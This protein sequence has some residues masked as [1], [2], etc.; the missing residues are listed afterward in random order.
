MAEKKKRPITADAW[1]EARELM[2][3]HRRSLSVGM[4]LMLINRISGLVLPASSKYLIDDVVGKG[5]SRLLVPLAVAVGIA[6]LIQA[7]TSFGLSQVISVAAQRAITEMR[8][9]VQ[10]QVTRLPIRFFDSTQS[11]VLVS[12]IMTD[13]EGIRNLV[14]TGIVQLVGGVVTAML[15][16]GV[17]IYLN[18][19]LTAAIIL[20]LAVF[21]GIMAFAFTRLR[22]IFRERSEINA[23]VTGRLT[24]T[25]GGIRVVKAYGT[26]KRE[27]RVF[28]QGAHRLFRNVARSITGVSAVTAFSTVVIGVVGVLMILVGGRAILDGTMTLG[29]LVMYIF[30]TGLLAAPVVQMASIG[31]QISEAFAGLD[32]IRELR[33]MVTEQDE[34]KDREPLESV[35]GDIT[36]QDVVFEYNAGVPVLKHVSFVAPAGT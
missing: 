36:F 18:W 7:V 29:D 31:T 20:L 24:E 21:G 15:A 12:R 35:H 32:R 14:G 2:W 3:S 10:A 25:L 23:A 33:S 8:R 5:Q 19:Q 28:T 6:T 22:P 27:Q 17:L 9:R 30:F 26:E 11:G 13:A 16:L 1:R 34:D 4:V